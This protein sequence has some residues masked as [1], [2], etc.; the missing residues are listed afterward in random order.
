MVKAATSRKNTRQTKSLFAQSTINFEDNIQIYIYSSTISLVENQEKGST[1]KDT[2]I[3]IVKARL[4]FYKNLWPS[5][6]QMV[7]S[8]HVKLV[9]D[10][11]N[12]NTTQPGSEK[13]TLS[14]FGAR[15]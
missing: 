8:K 5:Y 7:M 10:W 4:T 3:T 6:A 12:D 11:L 15:T 2:D 9:S 13:S 1:S 14:C